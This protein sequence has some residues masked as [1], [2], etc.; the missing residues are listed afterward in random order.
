MRHRRELLLGHVLA[1]E[2]GAGQP[3]R[4]R[5]RVALRRLWLVAALPVRRRVPLHHRGQG[6]RPRRSTRRARLLG[7]PRRAP[8]GGQPC[9]RV[10]HPR[11]AVAGEYRQSYRRRDRALPGRGEPEWL[12][13]PRRA[14]LGALAASPTDRRCSCDYR[15]QAHHNWR[16]IRR[17]YFDHFVLAPRRRRLLL[18]GPRRDVHGFRRTDH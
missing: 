14:G 12:R 18:H 7:L 15:G 13:E 4:S 2:I 1:L 6:S 5:D 11:L 8:H 9:R 3:R 10:P 17:L 16:F